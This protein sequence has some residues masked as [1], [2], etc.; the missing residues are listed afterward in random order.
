MK[1]RKTR[2][3]L[4]AA[5]PERRMSMKITNK[6]NACC[7]F[8]F[9]AGADSQFGL[10]NG[11]GFNGTL[12]KNQ[13]VNERK[14]LLGEE[15]A[16]HQLIFPRSRTVFLQTIYENREEATRILGDAIVERCCTYYG[17]KNEENRAFITECC[18][19]WYEQLT[20]GIEDEISAFFINNASFFT[21]LDEKFNDLRHSS[22]SSKGK[23]VINAYY[24]IF[25]LM[26][27]S[28]YN[29]DGVEWNYES[30]WE[31][32]RSDNFK[33]SICF[34]Q[35]SYYKTLAESDLNFKIIT[36]NYTPISE[37]ITGCD[38]TYLHGNLSWF[39][40]LERL[41]VFDCKN[42][43]ELEMLRASQNHLVPFILIPSG[44]K[45]LICAKQ[46]EQFHKFIQALN[47]TNLLCIVGY[48]FN[49]EDNHINSIIADWLRDTNNR[50][51]Y[52]N[53][54]GEMNWQNCEWAD[55][56]YKIESEGVTEQVD[57]DKILSANAQISNIV[58]N[59]DNSQSVFDSLIQHIKSLKEKQQ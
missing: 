34:E 54:K 12:L 5:L 47:E 59:G 32:L 45:P 36:T 27:S 15:Y 53:F 30:I 52:L 43:A 1:V 11:V 21:S 20:K 3:A 58:T 33:D 40:D 50:I 24:S 57:W 16:S 31:A 9:G 22:L 26:F 4:V 25:L 35:K 37:K 55:K 56:F 49:S 18:G 28:L 13:Y 7:A 29:V 23:R 39:E 17:K 14:I 19:D 48:K 38:V 41:T 44:I 51:I 2:A 6:N 8:L 42:D 10:V 46:I